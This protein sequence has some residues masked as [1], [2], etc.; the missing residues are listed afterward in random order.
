MIKPQRESNIYE[1]DLGRNPANHQPL[2][3][4]SYLTRAASVYPDHAALLLSAQDHADPI[5]LLAS[6]A[7]ITFACEAQAELDP[8][9]LAEIT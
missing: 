9:G 3:P 2:P 8:A 5:N 1:R 4:L 6:D 7:L